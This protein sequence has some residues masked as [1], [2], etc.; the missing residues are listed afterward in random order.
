[1]KKMFCLLFA[2]IMIITVL[3]VISVSAETNLSFGDVSYRI[4]ADG[5]ATIT[6]ASD[7]TDTDIVIP[8][9]IDGHPVRKIARLAF[10]NNLSHKSVTVPEGVAEIGWRAFYG[11]GNM[12]TITLPR[13]LTIIA[14]DAFNQTNY[15]MNK[16]NWTDGVLYIGTNL[17]KVNSDSAPSKIT[18][19]NG[20]TCIAFEAFYLNRT[21]EE[22][23]LPDT[24][25]A[26]GEDAFSDCLNLTQIN[27]NDN[28][29][30]MGICAFSGCESLRYINIPSSLEVIPQNAFFRCTSL[31][32]ITIP[33]SVRC[34]EQSAFKRCTSVKKIVIPDS[35]KDIQSGAFIGCTS[36]NE[37]SLPQNL[38]H[39]G[40]SI[41]NSTA[42]YQNPENWSEDL[43][44]IGKY[45]ISASES[46]QG[47]ITVKDGTEYIADNAFLLRNEIT[48]VYLPDSV[49]YIGVMAFAGAEALKNVRL[50]E[51]LKEIKSG[52]FNSCPSLES[53][54]IPQSVTVIG[55]N[56]FHDCASL[57]TVT[58]S[59]SVTEIGE[60]AFGHYDLFDAAHDMIIG[61]PVAEGFTL[62]GI[63]DS[64]AQ[65][66]AESEQLNFEEIRIGSIS[67]DADGDSKITVRD[68]TLIQKH[69]A[70]IEVLLS[71]QTL[72]C[73]SNSDGKITIGDATN[74]Q[75]TVAGLEN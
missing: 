23:N 40:S 53:I 2:V 63:T 9:E 61:T 48:S 56:A 68:A 49:K 19:K 67:G 20:T 17:I 47:H 16:A 13:T 3:P 33:E 75:K 46:A 50:P 7:I 64:P 38:E 70:G 60:N 58:L 51:D 54:Y 1:M 15:Y 65:S 42:Y 30:Y 44:Y 21:L 74:I 28:I 43:L 25:R 6:G 34:I 35:V 39:L 32:G 37:V 52:T 18:V 72:V 29:E 36:L 5:T 71:E 45:L 66:Y 4:E 59:S 57:K 27:L 55:K 12:N 14:R 69:L 22:V 8:A 10:S 26:I 31:S 24:I 41:I 73:D 62:R 11:C